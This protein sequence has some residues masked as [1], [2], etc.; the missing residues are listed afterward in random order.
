MLKPFRLPK[1]PLI[2]AIKFYKE[3]QKNYESDRTRL[4]CIINYALCEFCVSLN[5]KTSRVLILEALA[6]ADTNPLTT[7]LYAMYLLSSV[8]APHTVNR[9][10]AFELLKNAEL[11]DKN[12]SKFET[13]YLCFF[14][15][16]CYRNPRDSQ[17]LLNLGL[18]EYYI[19]KNKNNAEILFR[20]AISLTPFQSNVMHHWK[21][22]R[23]EFPEKKLVYRSRGRQEKLSALQSGKKLT[24]HGRVVID[25]PS[26][27]GWVFAERDEMFTNDEA[28]YWYN[29]GTGERR[30]TAPEDFHK[31]WELRALR[32]HF[33]GE[34]D[35]L[36]YY[37][38]AT[39]GQH[40]QRHVLS[41][42]YTT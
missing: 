21:I 30:Y 2:R 5:Y 36:E 16:G 37:Y 33:E 41:D 42:T 27:A 4:A 39:T 24:I 8:E 1:E 15:F 34:K 13:A 28:A 38:D 6:L 11:R 17:A 22:L 10:K 7:R 25:H 23:D 35:G 9:E 29:P 31:E 18:V 26:Y 12:A 32:S 3:S 19:Y 40:F 20:R 14:K